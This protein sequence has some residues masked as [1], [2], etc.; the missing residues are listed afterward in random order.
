[1]TAF[2]Y[3]KRS[4]TPKQ[5]SNLLRQIA[6]KIDNSRQPSRVAVTNELRRAIHKISVQFAEEG[7]YDFDETGVIR[8]VT[9][10]PG[11]NFGTKYPSFIVSCVW[12]DT[13]NRSFGWNRMN[14]K[15][16]VTLELD[17]RDASVEA[18]EGSEIE[19]DA[20]KDWLED[21]NTFEVVYASKAYQDAVNAY[22]ASPVG[23]LTGS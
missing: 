1:M 4:M 15:L 13:M 2:L 22:H 9:V 12:D 16:K 14:L 19:V 10:E 20:F 6:V 8:Q 11:E 21:D 23:V 5:F 7:A 17:G 3:Y 18:L